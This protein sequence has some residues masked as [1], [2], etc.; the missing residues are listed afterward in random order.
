MKKND[1]KNQRRSSEYRRSEYRQFMMQLFEKGII[2]TKSL[3]EIFDINYDAE[4]A[5]ITSERTG[6]VSQQLYGKQQKR[7]H[8]KIKA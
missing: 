6:V 4:M 2:S 3:L 1:K 7:C 5:Q 8:H